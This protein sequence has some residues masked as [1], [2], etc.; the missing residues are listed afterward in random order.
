M[1]KSR[2]YVYESPMAGYDKKIY[3]GTMKEA[4]KWVRS[5][6]YFPTVEHHIYKLKGVI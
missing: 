4:R 5:K 1:K 3:F 2:Y 6:P